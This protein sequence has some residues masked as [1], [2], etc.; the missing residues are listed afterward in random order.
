MLAPNLNGGDDSGFS[1]LQPTKIPLQEL[2]QA[3]IF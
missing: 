3:A 2:P 1:T